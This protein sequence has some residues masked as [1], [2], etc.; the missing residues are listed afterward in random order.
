MRR[1]FVADVCG[2]DLSMPFVTGALKALMASFLNGLTR[3][4][5]DPSA[6]ASL[7]RLSRPRAL[8]SPPCTALPVEHGAADRQRRS[9]VS[10]VSAAGRLTEYVTVIG[11]V[12]VSLRDHAV[13]V[14]HAESAGGRSA[15]PVTTHGLTEGFR[16]AAARA[17]GRFTA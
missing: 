3:R 4:N 17:G 9:P 6:N 16:D 11:D 12:L 2:H 5:H 13:R 1:P 14:H 15:V 10:A 8:T 7:C